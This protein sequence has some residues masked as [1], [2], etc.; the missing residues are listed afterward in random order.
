V[1][2]N[3]TNDKLLRQLH[4]PPLISV[5]KGRASEQLS[6]QIVGEEP[7]SASVFSHAFVVLV[8]AVDGNEAGKEL[9]EPQKTFRFRDVRIPFSTNLQNLV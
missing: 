1:I 3:P 9:A 7:V 4:S 8:S 2:K 6:G 5:N